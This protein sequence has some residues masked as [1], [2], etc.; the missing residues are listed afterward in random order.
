MQA[1]THA[2]LESSLGDLAEATSSK[3]LL[4]HHSGGIWEHF[5][6]WKVTKHLQNDNRIIINLE[7]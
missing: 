2:L 1:Q 4:Y 7:M 3:L 6:R 5:V